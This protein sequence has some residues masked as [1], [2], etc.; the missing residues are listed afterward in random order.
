MSTNVFGQGMETY[1][2]T[3]A[4][5]F[6]LAGS[7]TK[8]TGKY[9]YPIAI[10]SGNI[11]PLTNN[12]PRNNAPQKFG[13][14]RPLKWQYRRGNTS[15]TIITVNPNNPNE[16]VNTSRVSKT[17]KVNLVGLTIDQPGAYSVKQNPEDEINSTEQINKDCNKC[18]GVALITS[19]APNRFLTNRPQPCVTN[20]KFCCNQE[21]KALKNVI[22]A[23]TNLKQNYYNTHY[24]YLQ[25]RCQTYQQKSFNFVSPVDDLYAFNKNYLK[26]SKNILAKPGSPLALSN[27]YVANCYP[28]IDEIEYSQPTV[29]F[30][31]FNLL[32]SQSL[33][34]QN[35]IE[36]FNIENIDTFERMYQYL[37]N[38]EGD[39]KEAYLIYYNYINNPTFG[40]INGPS[41]PRGCKLVVYKPSNY[42]F[43]C[44][45]GVSD[46]TRLLKLTVDTISTNIN[47][48][49]R[50][51]GA[52][53]NYISQNPNTPF[54]Y[55]NKHTTCQNSNSTYMRIPYLYNRGKSCIKK[56]AE[57]QRINAISK[58]GNIGG[59]IGG[60]FVAEIGMSSS[61]Y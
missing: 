46:S 22:Y 41:N 43:A 24:Q 1:N 28:N 3:Q 60:T 45:G 19:F 53:T 30:K 40:V 38:I 55:K 5:P 14:P 8:G 47:S 59:N 34:T 2:N 26:N 17:S 16:Y 9:S 50:F 35:D 33:L 61:N 27:T 42:Q 25:N 57:F 51:S 20:P 54:I 12:D 58:L 36:K 49:R 10:T 32:K 6:T 18:E 56:G 15:N 39:K 52:S 29:I 48:I 21:Q 11:R 7:S 13:L 23:S 31:I 4:A 44:E 37:L